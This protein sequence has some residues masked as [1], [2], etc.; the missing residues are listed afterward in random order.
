MLHARHVRAEP[1]AP[2]AVSILDPYSFIVISYSFKV[3]P[4]SFSAVP[5]SFIVMN[6]GNSPFFQSNG[7]LFMY[8]TRGILARSIAAVPF[9]MNESRVPIR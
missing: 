3:I 5:D 4:Y 7:H 9:D 1:G 2:V 6:Q 8:C